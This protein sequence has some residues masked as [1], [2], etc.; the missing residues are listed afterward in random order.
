MLPLAAMGMMPLD[1]PESVL[2]RFQGSLKPGVTLRDLVNAIPYTAIQQGLLTKEKEGK[3]NIFSGHILEMEG[4]PDL[5]VDQAFE[6][7]DASAERSAAAAVIQLNME[8]VTEYMKSNKFFLEQ[9]VS[10]GYKD[11]DTIEKRIQKIE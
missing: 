9:L 6:L 11:R 10:E 2:V 8:P 3:K 7:T 4:L 5:T 1:M